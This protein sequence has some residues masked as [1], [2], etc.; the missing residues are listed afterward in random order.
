PGVH[1]GSERRTSPAPEAANRISTSIFRVS[2][3]IVSNLTWY[4][5][6]VIGGDAVAGTGAGADVAGAVA[7]PVAARAAQ[8]IAVMN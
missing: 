2:A 5:I 7:Q 8:A 6:P 1:A 3:V 4:E